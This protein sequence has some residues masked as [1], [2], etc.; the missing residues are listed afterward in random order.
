MT[1]GI[2]N[3][4][5]IHNNSYSDSSKHFEQNTQNYLVCISDIKAYKITD[6]HA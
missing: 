2:I 4:R 5:I 1:I 3:Y 6:S